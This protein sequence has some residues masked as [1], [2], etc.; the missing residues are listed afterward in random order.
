MHPDKFDQITANGTRWPVTA[1]ALDTSLRGLS[2][3]F[4]TMFAGSR[5]GFH[6]TEAGRGFSQQ[7]G[8]DKVP[9]PE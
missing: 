6:S 4:E 5:D 8:L 9:K 1:P 2:L 7:A 3:L